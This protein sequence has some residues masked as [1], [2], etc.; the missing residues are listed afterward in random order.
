MEDGYFVNDQ[1]LAGNDSLHQELSDEEVDPTLPPPGVTKETLIIDEMILFEECK[2]FDDEE[3][4]CDELD[5]DMIFEDGI[6]DDSFVDP[7]WNDP[8][9]SKISSTSSPT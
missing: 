3:D 8:E 4:T 2:D 6:L 9:A 5:E 7:D 1:D